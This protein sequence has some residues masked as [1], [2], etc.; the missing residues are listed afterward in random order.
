[1]ESLELSCS[2]ECRR[3]EGPTYIAT[4]NFICMFV[5]CIVD[6]NDE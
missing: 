4:R 5:L 1:M 6:L 3:W 2:R